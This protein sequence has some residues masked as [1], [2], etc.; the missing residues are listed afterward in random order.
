MGLDLFPI[1]TQ[2]IGYAARL[3]FLVVSHTRHKVRSP[4]LRE[5]HLL[6]GSFYLKLQIK[7]Q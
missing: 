7:L 6:T 5:K 3:R 4:C 1:I 2:V